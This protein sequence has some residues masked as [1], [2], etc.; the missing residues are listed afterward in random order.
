MDELK[1][2]PISRLAPIHGVSIPTA[3][4]VIRELE[5]EG[6]ISPEWSSTGRGFLGVT[7]W[8]KVAEALAR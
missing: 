4:R 5:A 6:E 3:K 1:L 8:Q 7:E 2:I